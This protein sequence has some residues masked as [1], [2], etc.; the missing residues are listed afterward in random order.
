MQRIVP[1]V[2]LINFKVASSVTEAVIFSINADML[3]SNSQE[4]LT[5][6]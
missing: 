5:F 1:L 3:D 4:S 6:K 2:F